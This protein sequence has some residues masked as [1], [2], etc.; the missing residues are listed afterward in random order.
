MKRHTALLLALLLGLSCGSAG[1]EQ[2]P[3]RFNRAG[4]RL[5]KTLCD[6]EHNCA[7]SPVSLALALSMA[8]EGAQGETRAQITALTGLETAEDAAAL[9][10]AL[11]DLGLRVA[12]V[13]F[14]AEDLPL[15]DAW[16]EAV[17]GV[18]G[19]EIFPLTDPEPVDAW[20]REKTGGLLEKAPAPPDRDVRLLL[21]NAVAM[22]MRWLEP[23]EPRATWE[24][25]FHAPGGDRE[26]PFMHQTIEW[27]AVY[28]ERDGTQALR[29][30]YNSRRGGL[31]MI[32]ALP[33]EGGMPALLSALAEEG[34]AWFSGMKTVD[35]SVILA[36]PK[37][38]LTCSANLSAPLAE[39]M[40][41]AFGAGA[42]FGALSSDPLTIGGVFQEVR[43]QIDE[44]GTKA[45][46]VTEIEVRD[47][48][49]APSWEEPIHMTADR[50]F[51]VLIVD[52]GTGSVCF[53][54]VVAEP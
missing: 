53:A 36:L 52:E 47:G 28:A 44:E 37:A 2:S 27:N 26:V 43:L 31:H 24:R 9:Q 19:G 14:A 7:L 8:A 1:A 6:G 16:R 10:A 3:G 11:E 13:A 35:R 21:M 18:L 50:P 51:L 30:D 45:A 23:F 12:D 29:L 39:A 40:P 38:D 15:R 25:T 32:V 4:F 5:L 41:L 48:A 46:A 49:A 42:D 20:V 17:T 33:P 22:D 34:L 54:A